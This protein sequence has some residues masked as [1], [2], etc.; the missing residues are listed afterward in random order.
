MARRRRT[1]VLA[2]A[3]GLAAALLWRRRASTSASASSEDMPVGGPRLDHR[4][5]DRYRSRVPA[6]H[7]RFPGRATVAGRVSAPARSARRRDGADATQS[8]AVR[9]VRSRS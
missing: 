6:L 7:Y 4:F 3:T 8:M 9:S 1:S 2:V 5:V